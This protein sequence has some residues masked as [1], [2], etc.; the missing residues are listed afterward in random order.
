MIPLDEDVENAPIPLRLK[1]ARIEAME[2][3]VQET[4]RVVYRRR[5]PVRP[6]NLKR[7]EELLKGKEG[8]RRRQRW[9]NGMCHDQ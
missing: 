3:Q 4:A 7:R 5:E 1:S 2:A 8:S 9:E 6:D